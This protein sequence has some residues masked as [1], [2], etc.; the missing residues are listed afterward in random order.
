[1]NDKEIPDFT[2]VYKKIFTLARDLRALRRAFPHSRTDARAE[3][4]RRFIEEWRETER[5]DC[6]S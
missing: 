2:A 6:D 1:M 5:R 4:D 3:R